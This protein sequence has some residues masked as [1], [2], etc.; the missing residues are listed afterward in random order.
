MDEVTTL[1]Y[2]AAAYVFL[3]SAAHL[4]TTRKR[5]EVDIKRFRIVTATAMVM[6]LLYAVK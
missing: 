2:I 5:K 1:G 3:T 6:A 4:V